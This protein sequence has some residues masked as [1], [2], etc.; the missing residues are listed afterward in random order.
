MLL[1]WASTAVGY[2][3]LYPDN[4][5]GRCV[6]AVA[7]FFGIGTVA[8]LSGIFGSGFVELYEEDKAS[9]GKLDRDALYFLPRKVEAMEEEV[10]RSHQAI[11]A[12]LGEMEAH[13]RRV[14]EA[15]QQLLQRGV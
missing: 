8:L 11:E 4:Y 5:L 12:R 14:D 10:R 9:E 13:M 6:S 7:A 15:L 1:G 3:D 2:G